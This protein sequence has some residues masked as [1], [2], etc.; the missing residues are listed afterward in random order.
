[1]TN[2]TTD[3]FS[4][5]TKV[6]LF[7]I[8]LEKLPSYR[9]AEPVGNKPTE[10]HEGINIT[11]LQEIMEFIKDHPTTW[12]QDSWFHV[13][14]RRTGKET[15]VSEIEEVTEVNSCGTSFCFAG[16]VGLAEGFPAPPKNNSLPWEREVEGSWYNEAI[17]DFARA[18]LGLTSGQADAL[19]DANNSMK[20]L[21]RMVQTLILIPTIS[22]YALEE[23]QYNVKDDNDAEFMEYLLEKAKKYN[24]K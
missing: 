7:G 16:H 23:I 21:E 18:R 12:Y 10:V 4:E 17:E 13:V 8:P 24:H 2:P 15:F 9:K 19:F 11:L 1:M 22:G 6:P 5:V 20:D 3:D 14:D